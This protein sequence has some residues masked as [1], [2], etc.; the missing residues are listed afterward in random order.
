MAT[1]L[2]SGGARWEF[3]EQP[4]VINHGNADVVVAG[5]PCRLRVCLDV[6]IVHKGH[7]FKKDNVWFFV[8]AVTH[9]D[10]KT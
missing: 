4:A 2:I 5:S 1:A 8:Y 6:L 3:L 9:D 10:Y 7:T